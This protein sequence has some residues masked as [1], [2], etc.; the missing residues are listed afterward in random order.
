MK[1]EKP[2]G[3]KKIL[4]FLL[5][6]SLIP[7]SLMAINGLGTFTQPYH[8]SIT[9][10]TVWNT[11]SN[12]IYVNGDITVTAHLTINSGLTIVFV[13]AGADLI[14]TGS[15]VLTASGSGANMIRF[16]ADFNNNGVYGE[17]GETWGH[18]SFQS[19]TSGFTTPSIINNCIIEYCKKNASPFNVDA[20]GGG[21]YTEYSYLTISNS[22]IHNNYAGYGGGIFVTRSSP[23]I[24]NCTLSNNTAGTTGGGLLFYIS[25][26]SLVENCIIN[27]NTCLGQGGAGGVFAGY[28]VG[29]LQFFNCDIVSNTSTYNSGNNIRLYQNTVA[30]YPKFQNC[31]VWGTNN[32]IQYISSPVLASNF[33]NCALQGGAISYTN[34]INISGINNDPTGPNFYSVTLGSEDYR[35]Q[36]IS[37]CRDAGTSTGAPLTDYLG[38][39]RIGNYDIGAYEVQYSRWNGTAN[40][41][42]WATQSNWDATIYPGSLSGTGDIIIPSGLTYYPTGDVSQGFVIGSG[43][44]MILNPGAQATFGSLRTNGTLKLESDASGISSL[45]IGENTNTTATVELYLTGGGSPPN[46]HYISSPVDSLAASVFTATTIDLAQYFENM[47]VD[48]KN[49]GW[50]AYDGWIYLPVPGTLGGPI[51]DLLNVGQGY[52]HYYKNDHT[53]TFTGTLNSGDVSNIPLAYHSGSYGLENRNEQ[54]FNLL[55]NPFSSCL[56]WSQIDGTLDPS[57]SQAIY[58]N[59]NG[60]FA[61][62]NN[63]VGTNGGT[64]TIPPMQGFFVKTYVDGTHL[65]LPASARVHSLSQNRY[66]GNTQIIPLVRLKLENQTSTDDAVV[67]FDDKATAGVDNA[68]DAYNFS[69]SGT[70][71]WTSTGGA[72]F[73]INGLPFPETSVEIPVS[74]NTATAGN[75][76]I[77]GTQIDGLENYKVT[78]T[79]NVNNITID[80]KTTPSLSFDAPGGTVAGRFVLKVLTVST[81]VP[82]TT[83]SDKP[84]NIYSSNGT[85]NIQTLSDTWNGKSGG[86][87]ILDMTGR[88]FTTEDNVV[89]SKDDMRQIPVR[90]AEGIYLV[91]IRSGAMRYVGKVIIR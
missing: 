58:F 24:F 9:V 86:I 22:F 11:I 8:G 72:D 48:N 25:S 55:G 57:I 54:G 39:N 53:Y 35:I 14:V 23:H 61:S 15:G 82:E 59:K 29:N 6:L 34:C 17:T 51:F 70:S 81:A 40:D 71:I 69:K 85:V 50:V 46:W 67:R 79:D 90:A 80:L 60:S 45:I 42:L 78:L 5:F 56:D 16:T 26:P 27:N 76:K 37:P 41:N 7:S 73:S 74:V 75:F 89:F 10:D 52:N 91:E 49:N 28:E 38:K 21:I 44:Y 64:G 68:F 43:K 33:T 20:T 3:M 19:M 13:S 4:F 18:I 65:T 66:K 32:W 1:Y 31:I 62:W 2:G 63:G 88:V 84:F 83:I 47:I 30:P 36:F 87:K 12:K 77:S